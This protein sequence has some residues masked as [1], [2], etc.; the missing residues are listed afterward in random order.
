[1][2][3]GV[4]SKSPVTAFAQ[5]RLL[6]A[7]SAWSADAALTGRTL[8]VRA[9]TTDAKRPEHERLSA[10]IDGPLEPREI[11]VIGRVLSLVSGIDV[12]LRAVER[13]D[14]AGTTIE[15]EPR[16]GPPK[17]GNRPHSPFAGIEGGERGRA[18]ESLGDGILRLTASGW[19]I[20]HVVDPITRANTVAGIHMAAQMLA[21][22][23]ET[24]AH[25][26]GEKLP[27][28]ERYERMSRTYGLD[29]DG[30]ALE[31]LTG[32]REEL[33]ERGFFHHPDYSTGR[34]QKDIKFLR[35]L[36]HALVF[37]LCGYTGPFF[38][39]EHARV[40]THR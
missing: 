39:F 22:A 8:R 31:R 15:S 32:L 5:T 24:V 23:I 37:R 10:S 33:L 11:E 35:D 16:N 6:F 19:P 38:S 14:A 21:L 27:P 13:C 9:L 1:M 36:A 7:G 28:R 26:D 30:P 3:S 17:V 18:V 20:D 40:T 2:P 29:L 34:P 25:A 12:Q 4:R